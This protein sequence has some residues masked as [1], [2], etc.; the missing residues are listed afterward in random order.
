MARHRAK[1]AVAISWFAMALACDVSPAPESQVREAAP[2]MTLEDAVEE[3]R[4]RLIYVPAYAYLY[5]TSGK[6]D[7]TTTLMVHNVSARAIEIEYVRYY[8][9][10]GILVDQP[11]SAPRELGPLETLEF[12]HEPD[13]RAQG[14]GANFLVGWAGN[15]AQAPLV[16]ALMVGQQG[17]GRLSFVSRGVEVETGDSAKQ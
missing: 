15:G 5:E 16:E 9:A 3:G 2:R 10:A 4:A 17:S 1:A 7:L 12:H 6:L 8:D 11:L 14:A 13:P